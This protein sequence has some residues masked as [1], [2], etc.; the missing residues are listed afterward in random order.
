MYGKPPKCVTG[1]L[2]KNEIE[3]TYGLLFFLPLADA[4][5]RRKPKHLNHLFFKLL[6]VMELL[7]ALEVYYLNYF[8]IF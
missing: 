4:F 1:R 5:A 6:I 2:Q 8:F 3:I 7:P